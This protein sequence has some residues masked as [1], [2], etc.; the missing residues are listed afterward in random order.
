[1]P[2]MSKPEY[3]TA[4]WLDELKF[5]A[6]LLRREAAVKVALADQCDELRRSFEKRM[7]D[8]EKWSTR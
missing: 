7:A 1:M 2:D 6:E 5:R 4:D 3:L 8:H